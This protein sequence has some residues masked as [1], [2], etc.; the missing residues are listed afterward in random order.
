MESKQTG[1]GHE[2]R[3]LGE[4]AVLNKKCPTSVSKVM[5]RFRGNNPGTVANRDGKSPSHRIR[6]RTID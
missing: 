1:S 4:I 3:V 2:N 6:I 5:T